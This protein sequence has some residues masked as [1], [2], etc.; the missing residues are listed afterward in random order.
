MIMSAKET[1]RVLVDRLDEE[2]AA[3]TLAYVHKLLHDSEMQEE[4]TT[5]EMIRRMRSGLLPGSVFFA[6]KT[7]LEALLQQQGVKP[8]TDVAT[9]YGDFWPEDETADEFIATI[10]RWRNEGGD[11]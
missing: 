3:E 8:I 10:R 11:A 4:L 9:L 1:L 2:S 7:D 5:D 6:Q